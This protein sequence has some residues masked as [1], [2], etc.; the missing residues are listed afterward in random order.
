VKHPCSNS[1]NCPF[2]AKQSET[3]FLEHDVVTQTV[4]HLET[5]P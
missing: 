4:T 2:R 5:G 3:D 1:Y